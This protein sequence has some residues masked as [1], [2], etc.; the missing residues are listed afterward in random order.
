MVASIVHDI[1]ITNLEDHEFFSLKSV[2]NSFL[3]STSINKHLFSPIF[4]EIKY[5]T[6]NYTVF[7][8]KSIEIKILKLDYTHTLS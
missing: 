5:Y 6:V 4:I 7:S 2:L 3:K 8:Y 1:G